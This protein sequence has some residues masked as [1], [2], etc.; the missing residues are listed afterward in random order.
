MVY[1]PTLDR[2]EIY[3]IISRGLEEGIIGG[4]EA[5]RIILTTAP[6]YYT[7]LLCPKKVGNIQY[8]SEKEALIRELG[9]PYEKG[10]NDIRVYSDRLSKESYEFLLRRKDPESLIERKIMEGFPGCCARAYINAELEGKPYKFFEEVASKIKGKCRNLRDFADLMERG[11]IYPIEFLYRDDL[12]P[13]GID[14]K[15]ALQ[16]SV[17]RETILEIVETKIGNIGL[18]GLKEEIEKSRILNDYINV[19]ES[20]GYLSNLRNLRNTSKIDVKSLKSLNGREMRN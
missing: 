1:T 17:E 2:E 12:V 18:L 7:R 8:S 13:H 11:E 19:L 20:V 4:E 16:A 14:C 6:S 9:I 10:E 15:P 5:F 3:E